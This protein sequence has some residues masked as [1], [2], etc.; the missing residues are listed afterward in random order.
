MTVFIL[1]LLSAI[2]MINSLTAKI[3]IFRRGSV[4]VFRKKTIGF[5]RWMQLFEL[6][7]FT[8]IFFSCG[9]SKQAGKIGLKAGQF[10]QCK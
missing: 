2:L 3:V 5:H 4:R 7:L 1:I 6:N 8:R 10:V 9:W